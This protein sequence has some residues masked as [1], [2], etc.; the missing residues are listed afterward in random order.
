M[1]LQNYPFMLL[2]KSSH[3]RNALLFIIVLQDLNGPF[4]GSYRIL[5]VS[6]QLPSTAI[7]VPFQALFLHSSLQE[8]ETRELCLLALPLGNLHFD[9][10]EFN[11]LK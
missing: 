8:G 11:L 4:L 1:H 9:D 6:L 5:S 10:G 2:R 7:N 3:E